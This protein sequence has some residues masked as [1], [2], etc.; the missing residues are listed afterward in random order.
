MLACLFFA[1]SITSSFPQAFR[2]KRLGPRT[3]TIYMSTGSSSEVGEFTLDIVQPHHLRVFDPLEPYEVRNSLTT[4][5]EEV[6]ALLASK[7]TCYLLGSYRAWSWFVHRSTTLAAYIGA[8]LEVVESEPVPAPE[9]IAAIDQEDMSF[10]EWQ[11]AEWTH[12]FECTAE[13]IS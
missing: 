5:P 1:G 10:L 7:M 11:L 4:P 12:R 3:R 6:V 9:Q 13:A 8:L 2:F